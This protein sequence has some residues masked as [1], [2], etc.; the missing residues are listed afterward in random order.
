MK[1]V[2]I[3]PGVISIPPNGWGAVEKIIWEY[4][5]VL[6]S[7]GYPTDIMYTDDVQNQPEQIVHVH[8]ANLA[9]MLRDRGI[10][11]VFSLHDHHVEHFGKGSDCYNQNYEAIKSSKLTFVHS[12]HLIP[13]F[14]NLP[15]IVYL[16]HGANLKDYQFTDRSQRVRQRPH[17]LVMMANNGIAG[18]PLSDRKGFLIGIEAAKQLGLEIS[19]I[20]PK[21]GNFEFFSHHN[22]QYDKLTIHYDLDHLSSISLLNEADIFLHPSNLEAGHPN[23]TLTESVSMGIPVVGTLDKSTNLPGMIRVE[24]SVEDFVEGIKKAIDTY[25]TLVQLCFNYRDFNSWEIVVSKMLQEYKEAYDIS[26]KSQ[27]VHNY[28]NFEK[29]HQDKLTNRGIISNFKNNQA[30]LRVSVFSNGL[31]SNFKD[32]KTGRILYSTAPGKE[33]SSWALTPVPL[34]EFIDWRIEV[35]EGNQVVYSDDLNLISKRVLVTGGPIFDSNMISTIKDFQNATGCFVTVK[36]SRTDNTTELCFDESADPEEFYFTLNYM[37]VIDFFRPKSKLEPKTLFIS[38][39]S[40]LGDTLGLIGYAQN[41]AQQNNQVVD[42]V[43][44][45][46]NIFD[47]KDYP[48]LNLIDRTVQVDMSAYTEISRFEYFF[49]RPLQRG[50]SDQMGLEYKEVRPKVKR[51]AGERPIKA[52]YVCIGVHTTSQC[53]YWNYPDA[54]DILCR[55]LRKMGYTPVSLDMHQVF[56]TEQ[57]WNKVPDSCVKKLGMSLDDI[58]LYL[59]HCEFFIGVSSGLSWLAWGI[60]KK[61]VMISGTTDPKNEFLEDNLRIHNDKVCNS[62]FTKNNSYKFNPGDWMWCPVNRDTP[63][64][65]E[66]T[67]SIT[68]DDVLNQII[69]AG[70]LESQDSIVA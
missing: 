14:D 52:K 25:D 21:K 15:Q 23:L 58:I 11:Y 10:P 61:V 68:P 47:P 55:K 35:K 45:F 37:Q 42:L 70:F 53:K 28:L 51:V 39:S 2:Q 24:R 36:S 8:M 30:F 65:F 13:F 44:K 4:K 62:C 64:W 20:C 6:D 48:N 60:G 59:Q 27:L 63:K 18:N 38:N 41:W 9:L 17:K 16:P 57:M 5:Q 22:P 31:T 34:N 40:A 43:I 3:T 49:D 12:K 69:N 26:E 56:G 66:C 46:T 1:V 19:I 33:P 7:L 50:Y 29:N 54:W 32:K 67:T